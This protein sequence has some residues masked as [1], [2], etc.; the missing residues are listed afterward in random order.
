MINK[1]C[2]VAIAVV[3][4]LTSSCG[5][6]GPVVDVC[7]SVPSKGGFICVDRDQ[8]AYFKAY[9]ESEKYI[10]FSPSDAQQLIEACGISGRT[11]VA[12]KVYLS[13][14]EQLALAQ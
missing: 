5:G 1:L 13:R 10:A 7:V 4:V 8:K 2:Y 11:K 12:V 6:S 9:A 3:L 14:V